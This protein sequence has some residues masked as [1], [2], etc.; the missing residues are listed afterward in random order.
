MYPQSCMSKYA[1][2]CL[3]WSSHPGGSQLGRQPI[4]S[5]GLLKEAQKKSISLGKIRRQQEAR[6]LIDLDITHS[7][8]DD[9]FKERCL[10]DN[11]EA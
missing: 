5:D 11:Y 6:E 2:I 1:K 4:S 9:R 10:D 8:P 7:P 3:G